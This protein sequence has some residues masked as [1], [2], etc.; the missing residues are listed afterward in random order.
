MDGR[1][2]LPDYS[3]PLYIFPESGVPAEFHFWSMQLL[4]M[5]LMEPVLAADIDHESEDPA[6]WVAKRIDMPDIAVSEDAPPLHGL[7]VIFDTC[8]F[9]Y[10][11][12][13]QD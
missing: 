4:S 5:T 9:S 1:V 2:L 3:P 7:R 6:H 11:R 13:V 8:E 12:V 10:L